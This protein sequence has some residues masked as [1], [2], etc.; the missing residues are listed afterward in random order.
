MNNL[1][2]SG[3]N[4]VLKK[5]SEEDLYFIKNNFYLDEIT[6]KLLSIRKINKEEIDK[7]LST[8]DGSE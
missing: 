6:S 5:F 1:S 3:R 2:I 4:W 8:T 7:F